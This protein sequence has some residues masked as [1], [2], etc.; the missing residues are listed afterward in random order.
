MGRSYPPEYIL[1]CVL[2][3]YAPTQSMGAFIQYQGV[4]ARPCSQAVAKLL[5]HAG[6]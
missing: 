3:D 1:L 6:E 4:I 2:G 5:S